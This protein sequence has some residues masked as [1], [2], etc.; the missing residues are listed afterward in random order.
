VQ[1]PHA[2]EHAAAAGAQKRRAAGASVL[3]RL[4]DDFL[5]L[6]PSRAAAEALALRLLEGALLIWLPDSPSR[7]VLT[8]TLV[9]R[10]EQT[11]PLRS[12][13]SCDAHVR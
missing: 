9:M 5:F 8:L 10:A 2:P 7:A 12:A 11:C 1:P 4:V 13:A 3:L 6:T